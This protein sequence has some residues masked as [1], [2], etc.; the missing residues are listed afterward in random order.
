MIPRSGIE[1]MKSTFD[2]IREVA[3]IIC[4]PVSDSHEGKLL[5]IVKVLC[6]V[7]FVEICL[8]LFALDDL[9]KKKAVGNEWLSCAT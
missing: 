5:K 6:C 4:L 9:K 2:K 8:F 7:Y 1:N 3:T